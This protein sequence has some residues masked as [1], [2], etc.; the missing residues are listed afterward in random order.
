M[1]EIDRKL[2]ADTNILCA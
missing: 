1:T 2:Y